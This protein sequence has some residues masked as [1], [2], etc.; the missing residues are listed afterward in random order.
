MSDAVLVFASA[1]WLFAVL[2]WVGIA[3]YCFYLM[4]KERI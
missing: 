4:F 1:S 3:G 2:V